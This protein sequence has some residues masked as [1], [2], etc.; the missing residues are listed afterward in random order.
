MQPIRDKFENYLVTAP[1]EFAMNKA[2]SRRFWCHIGRAAM[3]ALKLGSFQRISH[4]GTGIFHRFL[5]KSA[6]PLSYSKDCPALR[7]AIIFCG[8]LTIGAIP[9]FL[10]HCWIFPI[11]SP[12]L[13]NI[14]EEPLFWVYLPDLPIRFAILKD[15][16][17]NDFVILP[18]KLIFFAWK[19]CIFFNTGYI[20]KHWNASGV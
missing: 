14:V 16:S 18:K 19:G 11:I 2:L 9:V 3:I 12:S 8:E 6:N 5:L 7:P 17:W 15:A 1:H 4:T 10:F 20:R 13:S